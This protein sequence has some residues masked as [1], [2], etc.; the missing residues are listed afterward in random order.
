[1]KCYGLGVQHPSQTTLTHGNPMPCVFHALLVTI[2]NFMHDEHEIWLPMYQVSTCPVPYGTCP[3]AMC[4]NVIRPFAS[5]NVKFRLSRNST[6]FNYVPR[7]REMNCPRRHPRSREISRLR[8]YT[9]T[10]I[11]CFTLPGFSQFYVLLLD[12]ITL[13]V[14]DHVDICTFDGCELYVENIIIHVLKMLHVVLIFHVT[15]YSV[16]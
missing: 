9:V 16:K 12:S 4:H 7:F 6:K 13:C 2:T 11:S 3:H 10:V 15:C 14:K 5:K 1:M 8:V